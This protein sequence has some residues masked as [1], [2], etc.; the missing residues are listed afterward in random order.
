M[1]ILAGEKLANLVNHELFTTPIIPDSSYLGYALTVVYS[2]N[3][4]SPIAI[5]AFTCM[6]CQIFPMYGSLAKMITT[7]TN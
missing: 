7:Q 5:I 6:V 1:K 3:F 4:S 2:P